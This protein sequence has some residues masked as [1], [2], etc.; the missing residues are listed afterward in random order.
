MKVAPLAATRRRRAALLFPAH[1]RLVAFTA[2]GVYTAGLSARHPDQVERL[3]ASLSKHAC[4]VGA[5]LLSMRETTGAQ[6]WTAHT[7][8]DRATRIVHEATGCSV[9]SLRGALEDA[10]TPEAAWCQLDEALSWLASY[11]VQ[12]ASLPRMAWNLWRASLA[13]PVSLG[14]DPAIGRAALY[15]GRQGVGECREYRQMVALDIAAAYPTE[16][17]AQPFGLQL[18]SVSAPRHLDPT[19]SGLAR[20]RV[21]VPSEAAYGPLPVRLAPS[22]IS[23][24]RGTLKGIWTWRELAAVQALGFNVEVGECWA[25]RSS[26]DLFGPWWTM[27]ATGRN[28]STPGA[29]QVAKAVTNSLWGNFAMSGAERSIVRWSDARGDHPLEV[30]AK[31]PERDL[32]HAW[33]AHIAAEVTS[34]VRTRV[35][36][37][38]LY[39]PGPAPVH[40]DTDGV[41]VRRRHGMELADGPG[42]W[43]QKAAM[44]VLDLRAPQL[45][46][47]QCRGLCCVAH[48][49]EW[50]YVAAGVPAD[51]A[52]RVFAREA[53]SEGVPIATR[54]NLDLVLPPTNAA[55]QAEIRHWLTLAGVAP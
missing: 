50:H 29:V 39:G 17:A 2:D 45:Y 35:L 13:R 55:D 47:Y 4:Y 11:G 28:L 22:A 3:L 14:F 6:H 23:F 33:C 15:G 30:D 21:S 27:A 10:R 38:A 9:S 52:P 54:A 1:R 24:Q 26:G 43:R 18:R 37:E 16:M 20:A 44:R 42:H 46:R 48:Q 32:P 36:T 8:R 34:R 25:P 51:A 41:I 40:I 5:G 53:T 31:P 7:W 49:P 19:V 12:P